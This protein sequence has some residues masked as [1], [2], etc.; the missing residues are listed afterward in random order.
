MDVIRAVGRR[1][2]RS[3]VGASGTEVLIGFLV[4]AI[5]ASVLIPVA[6]TTISDTD[7]SGWGASEVLIWG[8]LPL[9]I[10]VGL[11]FMFLRRA[12]LGGGGK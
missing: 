1:I 3:Q 4:I 7:T 12:G 9:I 5:L 8:L 10:V 11:L 6:I 2:V